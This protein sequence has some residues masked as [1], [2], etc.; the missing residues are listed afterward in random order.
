MRKAKALPM[1]L[2]SEPQWVRLDGVIAVGG[3]IAIN[4]FGPNF[5]FNE[6]DLPTVLDAHKDAVVI[7]PDNEGFEG[8]HLRISITSSEAS[9][10]DVLGILNDAAVTVSG[11]VPGSA[12]AVNGIVIGIIEGGGSGIGGEDLVIGFNG[13]ANAARI[14]SLLRAVSYL[15]TNHAHPQG[16]TRGVTV[17]LDNGRGGP[18][19]SVS[20]TTSGTLWLNNDAPALSEPNT[21]LVNYAVQGPPVPL[22]AGVTLTDPD[23]PPSLGGG[24]LNIYYFGSG[25]VVLIGPR[26]VVNFYDVIDTTTNQK[27]GTNG[28]GMPDKIGQIILDPAA[29]P[30]AVNALIQSFGFA[31]AGANPSATPRQISLD[32][33]DDRGF[34]AGQDMN[35]NIV[36]QTV[37]IG[38]EVNVRPQIYLGGF[39][40]QFSVNYDS[41]YVAGYPGVSLAI[42]GFGIIEPNEAAGD[43][44]ESAALTLINAQAGDQLAY[45]TLPPGI[46]AAITTPAGRIVLTFT[47]TATT[48]V[49]EML[50]GDVRF[51]NGNANPSTVTRT[52]QIEASD[53]QLSSF[54][55]EARV[56]VWLPNNTPIA[57]DDLFFT[58]AETALAGEVY[59]DNGSGRDTDNDGPTMYVGAVNGS[60]AGI[61][62]PIV[63]PS[64]AS[65]TLQTDGHFIYDPSGAFTA[66]P[67]P[68][69]GASNAPAIDSFTYTLLGG[70]TATVTV[71]VYGVDSDGDILLGTAGADRLDG[72]I[73][74]DQ[75]T[76]FGGDDIY[77]VDDIGDTVTE[78]AGQGTD[79]IRTSLAVFSLA[80]TN[81]ENLAGIGNGNQELTG[82]AGAN[83]IDG[84]AGAD[85]LVGGTGNDRYIVD[86]PGDVVVETA[87]QGSDTVFASVTYR[88]AG[89]AHVEILAALVPAATGALN[90]FGNGFANTLTGNAGANQLDGGG[91]VDAMA[92][93][94][95]NDTYLFDHAGDTAIEAAGGG[96]DIVYSAVSY[97]LN[98]GSEVESLSTIS[99]EA[100]T[101][102][103]LTG[104]G[105]ANTLFGNAGQNRLDGKA[106]ADTMT[107]REGND[108]YLVDNAGDRVF[109]FAGGG[110][111]AV[112]AS[113]SYALIANGDVETLATVSFEATTAINLTGNGLAN[114]MIGNDGAN[115]L[116]GKAGA[117][118]M[119]GR[120]GNDKYFVDNAGDKTFESGGG[121]TDL[122]YA[123]VSFVLTDAQEVESLSTVTW[124]STNALNLTGNGLANQLFG[125]AGANRLDGRG[126]NDVLHGKGGADIFAFTTVLGANNVDVV[127]GFSAVDDLIMLENNGVFV[128]LSGGAL[129]P[130]AFVIGTAAQDATDRIV[131]HQPT[132]RLFFDA[133]G[134]GGSAQVQFAVLAGAPI[135]SASDFTVI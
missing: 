127:H 5:V 109:E 61:G 16:S 55:A 108:T 24:Q 76:G 104:N 11:V 72:G 102:L 97:S 92:G 84:G 46:S 94:G 91:G 3:P 7:D 26:F 9:S 85:R 119:I 79:E 4:N 21:G 45:G 6:D 1:D 98:D 47:G 57:C 67:A 74:A 37:T 42:P 32:F 56:N 117:D 118:V 49:Y 80:G 62:H 54:A 116:D 81:F 111:D 22:F 125:N 35:S 20:A 88:L 18:G 106:G 126:G 78:L 2:A 8:G 82:N 30:E 93:L 63:L 40:P 33:L 38:G 73:G 58:G 68:G 135:I 60:A 133:D 113:V 70:G 64:G 115:Q 86:N 41:F 75:M 66:T 13:D 25:G 59:L 114:Y 34:S 52:I 17:T 48:A 100:T 121:G 128:G 28:S 120:A 19:D 134:S 44:I 107:G 89:D 51:S 53:G 95:G 23:N 10:E 124:E 99:W 87:G 103:N 123:S 90:L 39:L 105:L 101:A 50:I 31:E 130:N 69:S 96:A 112:Y 12:V 29:T 122:I 43:R 131:Y 65:V 132:G 129:N 27:I 14:G 15:N 83:A 110:A 77:F 36:T 71:V